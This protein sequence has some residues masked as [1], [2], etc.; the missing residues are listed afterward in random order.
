MKKIALILTGLVL[1]SIAA[2]YY[3]TPILCLTRDNIINIAGF[4]L[5]LAGLLLIAFQLR[6]DLNQ[7]KRQ[8][9]HDFI[10]GPITATLDPLEEKLKTLLG[11]N[12]MFFKSGDTLSDHLRRELTT[13]AKHTI[14]STVAAILNFYERMAI[15]IF[16]NT[17]DEDICY[18]D[19]GFTFLSFH[20]WIRGHI[21][22]RREEVGDSRIWV[23]ATGLAK[24][25]QLRYERDVQR[26][27]K[28]PG[29]D[30][31]IVK[32]RDIF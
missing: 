20:Q 2:L 14:T 18:D 24:R 28:R 25:W 13:E 23:N 9:A 22:N 11:K 15:G 30:A 26:I 16:K 31:P 8:A 19:K 32:G 27:T 7:N 29:R 12:I 6:I 3:L 5:T 17:I 21:A 1:V 10:H 4:V